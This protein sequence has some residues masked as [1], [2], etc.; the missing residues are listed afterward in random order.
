MK[1]GGK[2]NREQQLKLAA[3]VT[4]KEVESAL[5]GISDLK[6]PGKDGLNAV[7][8]QESLAD[9]QGG[10]YRG[11]KEVFQH[12]K[13]FRAIN[14]TNVTLIPKVQ[15]PSSIKEYRPIACCTMLYK[16]ISL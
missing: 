8:F 5:Q 15:N 16:L 9:Y 12:K 3:P 2:L 4:R 11:V 7:F 10:N 6:A 13:M 14:C 1:E